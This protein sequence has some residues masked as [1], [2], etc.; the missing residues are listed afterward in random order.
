MAVKRMV[1]G[2]GSSIG[3]GGLRSKYQVLMFVNARKS[4]E[5][6]LL[7][8]GTI[9]TANDVW[10]EYLHY[11]GSLKPP[12]VIIILFHSRR[13]LPTLEGWQPRES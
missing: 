12:K 7:K 1:N 2:F 13:G 9:A 11:I 4:E 10:F 3:G 5:K 6:K 8:L